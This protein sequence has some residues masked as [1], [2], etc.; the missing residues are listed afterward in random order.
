MGRLLI[1]ICQ[2][3]CTVFLTKQECLID[4]NLIEQSHP[5]RRHS[6]FSPTKEAASL[7]SLLLILLFQPFF[8]SFL[9]FSP[10]SASS[11]LASSILASSILASSIGDLA[12]CNLP[13]FSF[14]QS[15]T[16]LI[17]LHL[18]FLFHPS[19]VSSPL[20]STT[21]DSAIFRPS[22]FCQST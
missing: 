6:P 18:L 8:I 3:G 15:L 2:A 1:I 5:N 4:A 19:L 7:S 17:N 12:F 13:P 22:A 16:L 21:L 9:S 11:I 14:R 10:P 20:P